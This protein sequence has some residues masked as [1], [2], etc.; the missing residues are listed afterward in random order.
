M[1]QLKHNSLWK[2][3]RQN[4]H[5][6]TPIEYEILRKGSEDF[7]RRNFY[8]IVSKDHILIRP[9]TIHESK[10]PSVTILGKKIILKD[11]S[12]WIPRRMIR[13]GP[14]SFKINED[15]WVHRDTFYNCL[16]R[17]ATHGDRFYNYS[18]DYRY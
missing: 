10:T 16:E 9:L 11:Y 15:R 14:G 4:Y 2:R 18:G 6:H 13:R 1:R 5:F 17:A 12:F 3:G 8:L 7:I